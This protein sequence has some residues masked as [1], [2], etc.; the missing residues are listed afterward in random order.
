MHCDTRGSPVIPSSL[1]YASNPPFTEETIIDAVKIWDKGAIER[2]LKIDK[3]I[4][5]TDKAIAAVP[6]SWS[7]KETMK[8]LLQ[9]AANINFY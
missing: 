6:R 5:I 1:T 8:L 3:N 4:P 7:S 9:S 2:L